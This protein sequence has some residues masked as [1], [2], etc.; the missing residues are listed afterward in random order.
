M[1]TMPIGEIFLAAFIQVL[2]E[3]LASTVLLK[4]PHQEQVHTLFKK[5]SGEL[6]EIQAFLDDAEEKQIKNSRVKMWLEDLTDLAYDLD[7]ILDEFATEALRRKLIV[8]SQ[9]ASTSK[10]KLLAM[11]PTCCTGFN[12]TPLF[13]DF[14]S[15]TSK[16]DEI[17]TQLQSI[18]ERGSRL[19]L[20]KNVV[21]EFAEA[22]HRPPA[23]SSLHMNVAYMAGIRR[24]RT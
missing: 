6:K 19:G 16:I 3:K 18:F 15:S 8:E 20:Q 21:G 23:T 1:E 5:W 2:F 13:S 4:F 12:P 11:I 7:D 14:M 17:T 10:S 9:A 24:K 22:W